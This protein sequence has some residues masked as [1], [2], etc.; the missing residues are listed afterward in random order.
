M[1]ARKPWRHRLCRFTRS[2]Y[3]RR[4][5][6]PRSVV[7]AGGGRRRRST[8]GRGSTWKRMAGFLDETTQSWLAVKAPCWCAAGS[9]SATATA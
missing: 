6:S 5:K 3:P 9:M 8:R 1:E 2:R 7:V 4:E